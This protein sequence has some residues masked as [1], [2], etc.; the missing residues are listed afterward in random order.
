MSFRSRKIPLLGQLHFCASEP[1]SRSVVGSGRELADADLAEVGPVAPCRAGTGV[2]GAAGRGEPAATRPL[3]G[4]RA[5][6][7]AIGR[8]DP[9]RRARYHSD[10]VGRARSPT[11]STSPGTGRPAG[12]PG[13][14]ASNGLTPHSLEVA[15][16]ATSLGPVV[17]MSYG[18]GVITGW[19]SRPPSSRPFKSW[20]SYDQ[21]RAR[22]SGGGRAVVGFTSPRV[23]SS[24]THQ[25]SGKTLGQHA[26][27]GLPSSGNPAQ[28]RPD[29]TGR[30]GRGGRRSRGW[31]NRAPASRA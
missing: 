2:A 26:L 17:G 15:R 14:T 21:A 19:G 4:R 16:T 6:A 28:R 12:R 5:A 23:G 9:G 31:S 22:F 3:R 13:R 18:S 29:R 7:G 24:R 11:S 1:K 8:R 27:T 10:S 25:W 30:P 20:G